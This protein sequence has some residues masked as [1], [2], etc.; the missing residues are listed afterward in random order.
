[1]KALWSLFWQILR[2]DRGPEEAPNSPMLLLGLIAL[3][4]LLSL[5]SQGLSK[6]QAHWDYVII[7]PLIALT[8]ELASLQ[9]LTAYKSVRYRYTQTATVIIGCDIIL[10]LISLPLS[11]AAMSMP[12]RSPLL[13]AFGILQMVLLGWGLGFRAFVYHRTI[14][15]GL[16]QANML[17]L[18]LYLLALTFMVQAFPELLAQAQAAAAAS[19]R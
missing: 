13:P 17:A 19:Q 15:I 10:T 1:M 12:D 3:D 18:A 2:F 9:L 6:G 5:L 14:N 4:Y 8:V 7:I 11:L 16:I